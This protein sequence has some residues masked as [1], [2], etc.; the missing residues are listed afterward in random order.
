LKGA[1]RHETDRHFF[2]AGCW[3]HTGQD[4]SSGVG[5]ESVIGIFFRTVYIGYALGNM[6]EGIDTDRIIKMCLFTIFPGAYRR[7]ELCKQKYVKTD[8]KGGR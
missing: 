8:E 5:A 4:S 6:A 7:P 2:E 3:A 1:I